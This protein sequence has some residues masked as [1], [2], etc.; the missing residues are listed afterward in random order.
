MCA[1]PVGE[2][3]E[4]L[5]VARGLGMDA[6]NF[7]FSAYFRFDSVIAASSGPTISRSESE[8]SAA[9]VYVRIGRWTL[10]NGNI[11]LC[12]GASTALPFPLSSFRGVASVAAGESFGSSS[13]LF[14]VV[15][16]AESAVGRA[17]D[18]WFRVGLGL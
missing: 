8:S 5:G 15:G 4:A 10:T 11:F 18:S 9:A 7:C 12:E 13:E 3:F 16:S 14:S 17:G 2:A 1:F 6:I